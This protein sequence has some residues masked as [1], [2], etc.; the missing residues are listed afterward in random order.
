MGLL[1]GRLSEPG[2]VSVV[3]EVNLWSGVC[4]IQWKESEVKESSL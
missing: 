4:V 2:K 1:L 3:S